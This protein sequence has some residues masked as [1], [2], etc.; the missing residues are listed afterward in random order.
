MSNKED[1]K[2]A[3]EALINAQGGKFQL[4]LRIGFGLVVLFGMIGNCSGKSA[5]AV[6]IFI[7]VT[8]LWACSRMLNEAM[9]AYRLLRLAKAANAEVTDEEEDDDTP[10]GPPAAS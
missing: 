9:D 7:I 1:T 2:K 6:P 5:Q 3:T 10:S 8:I 4:Y